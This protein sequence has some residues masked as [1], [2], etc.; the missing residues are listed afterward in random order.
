MDMWVSFVYL[1][2]NSFAISIAFVNSNSSWGSFTL[3]GYFRVL[4]KTNSQT[5]CFQIYYSSPLVLFCLNLVLL[6]VVLK[7]FVNT[8]S[9]N[10]CSKVFAYL[11]K[12]IG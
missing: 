10:L 4:P 7:Q 1:Q 6:L 2:F 8:N 9:T 11:L 5:H 3:M 12:I